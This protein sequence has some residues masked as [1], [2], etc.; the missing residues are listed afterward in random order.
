MEGDEK[1]LQFLGRV[2]DTLFVYEHLGGD[3]TWFSPDGQSLHASNDI[4]QTAGER[5][6]PVML[7]C[8]ED[9]F[10]I[11]FRTVGVRDRQLVEGLK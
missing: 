4:R 10:G 3:L 11:G 5:S 6:T 1:Y 2:S 7:G 9:R 8:L